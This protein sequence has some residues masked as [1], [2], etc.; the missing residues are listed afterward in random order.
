MNRIDKKFKDLRKQNKKAFIIYICAGDPDLA[1]TERL[2]IEL[3][4]VGVDIVELGVPFSD[5]LADGPTIQKASQRALKNRINL[6]K[7]FLLVKS[8]RK[9][10]EFPLVLMTYYNPVYNYGVKRFVRDAKSTG[11]D[12]VIVPDL[13]PEEAGELI[14]ASKAYRFDTVF[15]AAPTSTKERI[16]LI[17]QKSKGF[18]YYVSLTGVTG[19]RKR[20]PAQIREHIRE[21][22][23]ITDKPVC[24]GFGVSTPQQVRQLSAFCD[25]V[26][27]GS[28][29]INRL[30][31]Y[32]SDRKSIP[33]KVAAFTKD[34]MR[35]G[36]K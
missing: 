25:G 26:I 31:R 12:G 10:T 15:L 22:K 11:V 17:A 7:I 32:L 19:A 9:R 33:R 18:I 20:L 8:L 23:R 6:T 35:G 3:D 24:V 36:L 21:I 14:S 29:I 4:R 30:E 1:I 13:S 16:R 34:L 27:I 28:A 2:V 5:P